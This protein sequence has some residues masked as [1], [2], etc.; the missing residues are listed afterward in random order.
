M[1]YKTLTLILV[2]FAISVAFAKQELIKWV[3]GKVQL[4]SN[5][6]YYGPA[7]ERYQS[8]PQKKVVD[9]VDFGRTNSECQKCHNNP[10]LGYYY[11]SSELFLNTK[12]YEAMADKGQV[13][14]IQDACV[15]CHID[16]NS[17]FIPYP[18]DNLIM[19]EP[20]VIYN[21]ENNNASTCGKC[22]Q[23]IAERNKNHIMSTAKGH[24]YR[25]EIYPYMEA[26]GASAEQ[27]YRLCSGC[28][29]SCG[30]SCHMVGEDKKAID[31]T[32]IQPF[33]DHKVGE[34]KEHIKIKVAKGVEFEAEPIREF[35]VGHYIKGGG[36]GYRALAK[37]GKAP[38]ETIKLDIE[39]H[40]FVLPGDLPKE[41]ADDIC[42][43]CHTCMINPQD[44]LNTQLAHSGIK[45]VDCHKD[46]DV[47][48]HSTN[49]AR[50]AYEAVDASCLTCHLKEDIMQGKA[51]T[52]T[53]KRASPIVNPAFYEASAT[54]P[55]L[56]GAHEKVS[57]EVCHAESVK[58]CNECHLGDL[59]DTVGDIL[60]VR[61]KAIFYGKDKNGIVRHMLIH[62]IYGKDSKKHGGWI[63]KYTTHG[64]RARAHANCE[65]CHTDPVRMGIST[66]KLRLINTYLIS[67]AGVPEAYIHKNSH[68]KQF[69]ASEETKC[70]DCHSKKDASEVIQFHQAKK[71]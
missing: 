30:S 22:H 11:V 15:I 17:Q 63:M 47:H 32:F 37:M 1:K 10:D 62:Q 18:G 25:S 21:V 26:L 52:A 39:S 46:G 42:L 3:P 71:H 58:Q 5:G 68:Y 61:D 50:F 20:F 45:C 53:S 57:C 4:D 48:G 44:R 28:H 23:D 67:Q 59:V 14:S 6:K 31:W 70:V 7:I 27:V 65:A 16:D 49:P 60:E 9:H 55:P 33:L 69:N 41:T 19:P 2:L 35:L 8:E 54:I 13:G 56:M 43:R 12:H 40:E 51:A 24:Y 64:L 66:P 34:N 29:T 36:P 38:L